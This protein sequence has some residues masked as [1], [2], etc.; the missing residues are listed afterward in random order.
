MNIEAIPRNLV[1]F[2][3]LIAELRQYLPALL[4]KSTM[5]AWS[6][7]NEAEIAAMNVFDEPD[8]IHSFF[9]VASVDELVAVA[10]YMTR[11]QEPPRAAYFF[12]LPEDMIAKYELPVDACPADDSRCPPIHALHRHVLIGEIQ[13]VLMFDEIRGRGLFNYRVDRSARRTMID[14]LHDRHCLDYSDGPCAAP[15]C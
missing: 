7:E 5:D 14:L 4:R 2:A 13:R 15:A 10:A 9:R 8:G 11:S 12:A 3:R 6:V 1:P